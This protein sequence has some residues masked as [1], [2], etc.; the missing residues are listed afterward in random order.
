MKKQSNSIYKN[1]GLLKFKKL[2]DLKNKV[3]FFLIKHCYPTSALLTFQMPS[4]SNFYMVVFVFYLLGMVKLF[5]NMILYNK[6]IDNRKLCEI[7]RILFKFRNI[8]FLSEQK[9]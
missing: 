1:F 3:Y 2:K 4:T 5:M 8:Q 7:E 9:V 6:V